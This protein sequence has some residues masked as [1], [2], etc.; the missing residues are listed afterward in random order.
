MRDSADGVLLM[1]VNGI[2]MAVPV[3]CKGLVSANIFHRTAARFNHKHGLPDMP[4][5]GSDANRA[6]KYNIWDNDKHLLGLIPEHHDLI[7][8][9]HHAYSYGTDSCYYLISSHDALLYMIKI[10]LSGEL[11][12]LYEDVTDWLHKRTLKSFYAKGAEVPAMPEITKQAFKDKHFAHL[13]MTEH[14]FKGYV[15]LW[16]LVNVNHDSSNLRF[17]IPPVA[18]IRPGPVPKWNTLRRETAIL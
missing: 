17:P 11:L 9:L 16:Q 3:E 12:D 1:K 2:K 15:G 4:G 13:K 18:G 8:V 7:Q 6:K 10:K 5:L 14:S